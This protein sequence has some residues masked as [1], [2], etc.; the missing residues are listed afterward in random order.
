MAI[1]LLFG[2]T[3]ISV[4]VFSS[5]I[6]VL[7][8][9]SQ[10]GTEEEP[11]LEVPPDFLTFNSTSVNILILKGAN[12]LE[13]NSCVSA[14]IESLDFTIEIIQS[15]DEIHET[16]EIDNIIIIGHGN[17]EEIMISE[18]HYTWSDFARLLD[19]LIISKG[20]N[21][22]PFD[23]FPPIVIA[24]C[25]AQNIYNH[26]KF[27][28]SIFAW[29]DG[30]IDAKFIGYVISSLINYANDQYSSWM[31]SLKNGMERMIAVDNGSACFLPLVWIRRST[32]FIPNIINYNKLEFQVPSEEQ[33]SFG[34]FTVNTPI[35]LYALTVGGAWVALSF[36][37]AGIGAIGGILFTVAMIAAATQIDYWTAE[38][39]TAHGGTLVMEY[40][41]W[42][43]PGWGTLTIGFDIGG[44]QVIRFPVL[45]EPISVTITYLIFG[46]FPCDWIWYNPFTSTPSI[47]RPT[48]L[49]LSVGASDTISYS[50]T[51]PDFIQQ[52]Y[53]ISVKEVSELGIEESEQTITFSSLETKTFELPITANSIGDYVV[54]LDVTR[55]GG[56]TS[57]E[58]PVYV[59]APV[60]QTPPYISIGDIQ[61]TDASLNFFISSKITDLQSGISNVKGKIMSD[62]SLLEETVPVQVSA[63]D[64]LFEFSTPPIFGNYE[65][66]IEAWDNV[67]NYAT[68]E[69][70]FQVI[71]DDIA[72]PV[73][74]IIPPTQTIT[75]GD[76]TIGFGIHAF[77]QS[78]I[79]KLKIFVDEALIE[80]LDFTSEG[81]PTE[82]S[83][84]YSFLN[85]QILGDHT[86]SI[87]AWDADLDRG[88]IDQ[89]S[90]SFTGSFQTIDDDTTAPTIEI[91][92]LEGDGTD[93]SPGLF[94]WEIMDADD[95]VG[96]DGDLGFS[97]IE[98]KVDYVSSDNSEDFTISLPASEVGSWNLPSNLGTYTI[99]VTATDNDDDRTSD[100]LTTTS[101]INQVIIDDDVLQP[102]ISDLQI[103]DDFLN[104][105]ISFNAI[106]DNAGDDQGIREINIFI[107]NELVV[108]Y[109]PTPIEISYNFE[110]SN[111]RI[112]EIGDHLVRVEVTDADDDRSMDSLMTLIE[113][114]FEVTL[115][116]TKQ[117]V[118][119]EIDHLNEA[120]QSSSDDCWR[121]PASNRKATMSE[122]LNELKVLITINEF[123]EA[124]DKLLHDIKPKLTGLKTDENEEPWGGGIFNNPWVTCPEL[125]EIFKLDCNRILAH[126]IV[127]IYGA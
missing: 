28:N 95:G 120:I 69:K 102:V 4:S 32:A 64:Y 1:I 14:L 5:Y 35:G 125:Q 116:E 25:Y 71:D 43:A 87:E 100:S 108:N 112:M 119:W 56:E 96:G 66:V 82:F 114:S 16:E 15:F 60:D 73:V 47:T 62:S 74:Y 94:T 72:I 11:I 105:A 37:T 104:I 90:E 67:N 77:D 76:E 23:H 91:E 124:Y 98:I 49:S 3:F 41:A 50:I 22:Y 122:K 53:V 111:D 19:S 46:L 7:Q 6:S 34:L 21:D 93:G 84:E 107:D 44:G 17:S 63:E 115:E 75:D 9:T 65:F 110:L 97:N 48:S 30:L 61:A 38:S 10:N 127:L 51:N 123:E 42:G 2:S 113:E 29:G 92:Y 121:N 58:I 89:L 106:D 80:E 39:N 52:N 40:I 36:W 31:L 8:I 68:K 26:T 83:M 13:V 18:N 59:P 88:S 85:P 54:E 109:A 117:Y 27:P 70:E 55:L 81:Y 103:M 86:I 101:L 12:D 57:I 79:E 126:L 45:W 24:S 99:T 33:A 118:N 78:G 20:F